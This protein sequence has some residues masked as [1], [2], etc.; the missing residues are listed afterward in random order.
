MLFLRRN[1]TLLLHFVFET[2]SFIGLKRS[3]RGTLARNLRV[4]STGLA[5]IRH[6]P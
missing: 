4:S 6:H 3:R 1:N 5:V 2:G